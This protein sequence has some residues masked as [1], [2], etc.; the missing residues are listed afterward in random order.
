MN[1]QAAQQERTNELMEAI[2]KAGHHE[3]RAAYVAALCAHLGCN[4]EEVEETRYD[5]RGTPTYDTPGGEYAVGTDE[6]ADEACRQYISE[7]VWAFR[8]AFILEFCGL[9]MELEQAIE[10]FQRDKCE[11]AND[12][13]LKLVTLA[14]EGS[15]S[16]FADAAVSA[17]GRGHF[18]NSYDGTEEEQ[19]V[20]STAYF[21]YRTN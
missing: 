1:K 14:G 12:A 5:T 6:D 16:G 8:A 13:L 17:D 4:P 18:L 7:S 15:V 21:I 11:G 3:S 10:T 19:D 2:I 20:N 9:P